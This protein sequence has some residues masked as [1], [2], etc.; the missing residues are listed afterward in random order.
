MKEL[1]K[2]FICSKEKVNGLGRVIDGS[3]VDDW[4]LYGTEV[5]GVWVC[6]MGCYWEVVERYGWRYVSQ[7]DEVSE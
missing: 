5:W 3:W 1:F 7:C 2:C 4:R 6:S